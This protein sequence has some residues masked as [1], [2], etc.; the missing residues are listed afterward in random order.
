MK[1]I[2]HTPNKAFDAA[3]LKH[4]PLRSEMELFKTNLIRL[5]S[6]VDEIE[7]EENQ[8]NYIR[9]F[10]RDIFYKESNEINTKGSQDLVI[11]IGKDSKTKVGVIIEAKRPGNTSEMLSAEK[12]NA[13]A[14]QELVLY[15][16]RERIEEKNIDIKYCIATNINEWYIF[17]ASWFEKLFYR[18]KAFVKQY[19][20]WR[21]GKKITKDTNLFYNEIAKPFIESLTDEVPCTY[22]DIRKYEKNL[23]NTDNADDKPL[24]ALL[25]VLSPFHLL[26]VPFADDSNKLKES[27]YQELLH[28]IGLEEAKEGG[29]NIIRRKIEQRN[30]G[31]LIENAITSLETEDPLHKV[32]DVASFGTTKDERIFNIALE[33]CI[34]WINRILFLKLLEGQLVNYHQGNRDYRFLNSEMIHDFDELFKL[35]HQVLARLQNERSEANKKKFMRIPYLNSSLFEISD[36]EDQTIRINSLDNSAQLELISSTVLKEIKK[37][38]QKLPAL[39]YLFKFLDAFDFASE[40]TEDIEE[41]NKTLINSSVLGKVYEKINGYKDGS[42]FTPGFITM[43]MCRQSIRLAVLQKFKEA[44]PN[45]NIQQF[46]DIKNYIADRKSTKDILEFNALIN[47]LRL[48][49]PAVGSG[50][51]LVSSLNEIIAIKSE[52]GLLADDTGERI[53]DFEIEIANDELIITDHNRNIFEYQIHNAHLPDGQGKPISKEAQRLQKTLFHEKQTII[54]N[55]LFG[56][57]INPKSVL[58]C[59]LRLWIELLKNAYYKEPVTMSGVEPFSELE[60][61]PNIDI[62]IKC[63]NSLLSRFPL[64][65]DLSKALKSIKYD[66]NA[67]RGFVNDYKNEKSREVKRGLQKIID[68]IKS[69]F[70]T[71]IGKND[72]KQIRLSKISGDLFNLLNQIKIFELDA[73]QK[74]AQ[75]EKK[76]KLEAEINRL[77]KEIDEIKTN[78]LY[79]N[80][81]EWRF[82][83]P[84][85][86]NNDGDYIGFDVVIGNPPYIRQ[87][88]IKNQKEYLLNNYKT[89]SSTADLYVFFVER[90]FELL[91]STGNFAYIIPNKW[92]QAGYGKAMRSFLLDKQLHSI[93]DFGD[94]QVFDNVTTYP[95]ILSA[96]KIK[97]ENIFQSTVVRTL[98]FDK[99][100]DEYINANK[101]KIN[102]SELNDDSWIISSSGERTLLSKIK[103][104][105]VSLFEYTKGSAHYGIKTG[106]TEAFLIDKKTKEQLINNDLNSERFIKPFLQGR[107]IK[108]YASSKAENWLIL[109][110]KGFTIKRNLPP[111]NINYVKEPEPRYGNMPYDDAWEWFKE[112]YPAIAN[113]LLPYKA[114]AEARTDKGDFW[115]ELRACDYY[116]EFEQPKIMYQVLQVKPCFIY[117]DTNQYCNNSMWII[118]KDDKCLVG[119][120]NSKMGWWL[121]SNYC[122]AIQNGFQLIWKYF[123]QIPIP[124]ITLIQE[125]Q[126]ND[127][128]DKVILKKQQGKDTTHNEKK[129][130]ELV[131]SLYNLSEDEIKIVEGK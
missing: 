63:G 36:L 84:E 6:K 94:L 125:K 25:K 28:I 29:K 66:M 48:C 119:I 16:L 123:G 46:D 95:C 43:Y 3:F 24:I 65:A 110:P 88:E 37:K 50:H 53:R 45:W 98:K 10:L 55:C 111:N 86:L 122:T 74:K 93:I 100:F 76:E 108:P 60:T 44:Y 8:K 61:L 124:T 1:L 131:Y 104:Q 130:D 13:K 114:K 85:V 33:L 126:M 118:P 90:G 41:D 103:S 42:I 70:R 59:R 77:V 80:A 116:N 128:V 69:D 9:D 107:N 102:S 56:V 67:Y 21:D 117:D 32:V 73:K 109:I 51:F 113:H 121:I 11:H 31:S 2:T 26:K 17:E 82:E 5:L 75:K 54:E 71:E 83:F 22:F 89:Y 47:S 120:L 127:L 87:E 68:T 14:L 20:D 129:I 72:P 115:W 78:A 58:I 81:F 12:P 18:N 97:T 35:F 96:S 62:N 57:D 101:N 4:R 7:R 79:K 105:S 15:Y 91:K 30:P 39:D 23:K 40:G 27:F 92:M 64:N 38:N 106:L 52:L 112:N 99:G 19:E 49:D 34:T